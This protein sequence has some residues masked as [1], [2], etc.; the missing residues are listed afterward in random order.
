M[1]QNVARTL[2]LSPTSLY[3]L[4]IGLLL[5]LAFVLG[6]VLCHL[7]AHGILPFRLSD[8]TTADGRR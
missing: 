2:G 1:L 4:G 6:S 7:L 8:R 3:L 5:V